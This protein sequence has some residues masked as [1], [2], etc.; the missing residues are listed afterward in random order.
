M[1]PIP[2]TLQQKDLNLRAVEDLNIGE[3]CCQAK[4]RVLG[5]MD[6]LFVQK[7]A[8]YV[9]VKVNLSFQEYNCIATPGKE[10]GLYF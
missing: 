2:A 7:A 9:S 6:L 8:F 10:H 1:D 4:L 5:K 3:S